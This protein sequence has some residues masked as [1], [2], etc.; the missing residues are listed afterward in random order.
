R[1]R[2]GERVEPPTA[3]V[4]APPE[5]PPV[6]TGRVALPVSADSAPAPAVTKP[7]PR[8]NPRATEPRPPARPSALLRRLR[9][10][11]AEARL[12]AVAA[13]VSADVLARGDQSLGRA[14]SLGRRGSDAEA[15]AVLSAT[16]AMWNDAAEE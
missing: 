15:A 9:G 8:M 2:A 4:P 11:A 3:A 12:R 16:A 10:D 5:T 1:P 14:D 6:D 13:G 7:E